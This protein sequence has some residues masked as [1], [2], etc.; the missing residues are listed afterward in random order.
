MPTVLSWLKVK[1]WNRSH[2]ELQ[3]RSPGR[4]RNLNAPGLGSLPPFPAHPPP[5]SSESHSIH[6]QCLHLRKEH[7]RSHLSPKSAAPTMGSE[8]GSLLESDLP[9][10]HGDH[11][12]H[13]APDV[14]VACLMTPKQLLLKKHLSRGCAGHSSHCSQ[15]DTI[16][17]CLAISLIK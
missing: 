9:S 17:Y 12:A 13:R 5:N 11:S 14:W 2:S 7:P 16:V 3:P 6:I 1:R 10:T 15:G 8:H 4:D